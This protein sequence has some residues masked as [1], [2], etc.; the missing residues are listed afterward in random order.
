LE[1][2]TEQKFP[3]VDAASHEAIKDA[4]AAQCVQSLGE[5]VPTLVDFIYQHVTEQS[6]VSVVLLEVQEVLEDEAA[7]F[8]Q[9][10]W[11]QVHALAAGTSR[12]S[13]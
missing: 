1:G 6:L 3:A 12:V 7:Q 11:E 13:T 9:T 2:N 5:P 10:L 4:I 8:V